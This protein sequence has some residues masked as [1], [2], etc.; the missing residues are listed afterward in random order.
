MK[1]GNY[2]TLNPTASE[3][4][5]NIIAKKKREE[6]IS[7]LCEIYDCTTKQAEIDIDKT[8][9]FLTAEG[10]LEGKNITNKK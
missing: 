3:I 7:N 9:T 1:N 5:E 10:L 2:Y 6:I 8:L 4:W